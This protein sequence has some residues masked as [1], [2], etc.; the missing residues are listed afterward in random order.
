MRNIFLEKSYATTYGGKLVP[1]SF[2][3]TQNGTNLCV[4]SLKCCKVCFC[5]SSQALPKYTKTKALTT[6]FYLI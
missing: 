1:G 6:C 5:L 4:N 3:K 2:I